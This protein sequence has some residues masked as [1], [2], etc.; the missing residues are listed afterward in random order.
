MELDLVRSLR[1]NL[2]RHEQEEKKEGFRWEMWQRAKLRNLQ[3]YRKESKKTVDKI[4]PEVE[5]VVNEALEGNYQRGQNLF[6]RILDNIKSIFFKRKRV[7]L[8]KSIESHK[9]S[10]PPPNEQDFFGVNKNKID[11]MQEEA[12]KVNSQKEIPAA[13]KPEDLPPQEKEPKRDNAPAEK[14]EPEEM[15]GTFHPDGKEKALH[16]GSNDIKL[17][18]MKKKVV[19][20]LKEAQK[21]VWRRM[22]DIYRQTVYRAGMN[23]AAGAKTLDQAIDM[24]TKEFLDAGIDCIEYKNGRRVNIASYAEMALR[25]ASQRAVLLGEGKKRDEWGIH[26]VVVSAH[27]NTCP[28]CAPWQGKV[29]IDDV[30]SKGTREE[31]ENPGYPALSEAMRAGLLHPNCRHTIST[32][33]PGITVLP[34]VPDTAEA[35]DTYN[36]E[37]QQRALERK[38]RKWKRKEEGSCDPEN[39]SYANKKVRRYQEELRVHLDRHPNLRRD[40]NREKTRG[41]PDNPKSLKGTGGKLSRGTAEWNLRRDDE[42]ESYYESLRTRN[43]DVRSVA[44]NVGWTERS[45][46]RI[47]QHVFFNKHVLDDGIRRFDADYNMAVAWQRLING[48][49]LDRDVLLL[50]HE[51]LESIIEKKYNLTYR[52]AHDRATLKH[53]WNAVLEKEAGEY[54]EADNLHELIGKD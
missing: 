13:E 45:V 23:M 9:P 27:A 44:K 52:E 54:G 46:A 49:Y 15:G 2:K 8:P 10:T 33:F 36:A 16:D 30:F 29:L 1:R 50:K 37:Q 43:D 51:Y 7:K 20:D 14:Q 3:K 19:H 21:A 4:S 38:I 22:D 11:V 12:E 6:N 42:A 24:A 39:S 17:D 40:Y 53:D 28:L 26:T 32:Y 25:T 41:V 5:R 34:E 31:A 18:D 48:D 35:I 47:K